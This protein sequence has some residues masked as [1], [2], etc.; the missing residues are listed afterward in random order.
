MLLL[1]S[2]K[3]LFLFLMLLLLVLLPPPHPLPLFM[4]LSSQLLLLLDPPNGALKLEPEHVLVL[5]LLVVLHNG[6]LLVTS[7]G[8]NNTAVLPTAASG[9]VEALQSGLEGRCCSARGLQG[10][11]MD[12]NSAG[13]AGD[14]SATA[15]LPASSSCPTAGSDTCKQIIELF[16]NI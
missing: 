11:N 6:L 10:S 16:T 2:H 3:L 8:N 1:F 14:R 9:A 13:G 15:S 7:A 4:L 5:P 12:F